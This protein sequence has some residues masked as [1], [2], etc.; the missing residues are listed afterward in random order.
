V[1]ELRDA[2][3]IGRRNPRPN[4]PHLAER[5][6]RA[7]PRPDADDAEELF[8]LGAACSVQGRFGEAVT[9]FQEALQLRPN[10]AEGY[11][12]LG[13]ALARQGNLGEAVAHFQQA[14]RLQPDRADVQLNLGHALR[15]QGRLDEAVACYRQAIANSG[16][17]YSAGTVTVSASAFTRNSAIVDGGGIYNTGTL[18]PSPPQK[19][20]TFANNIP[21]DVGD[22]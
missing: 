13:I 15:Q 14:L 3:T 7:A 10:Q 5:A 11:Q 21:D 17:L 16:G 18:R 8:R 9:H 2:A 12:S 22:S 20:N 4:D 1:V 19:F 6:C